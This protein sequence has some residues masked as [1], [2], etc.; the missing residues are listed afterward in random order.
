MLNKQYY[1]GYEG[2]GGIK[3]WYEEEQYE[4]GM[5]IWIGFWET[6]LEG[7]YNPDYQRNGIAECYF[8]H[9]GFYDDKWEMKSMDVVLE[10]LNIFNEKGLDTVD[11]KIIDESK[12]IIK[13]LCCFI[14]MAIKNKKTVYIE[15]NQ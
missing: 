5:V 13:K 4:N 10:E 14:D 9:D 8:N 15:Y 7:C 6:I 1:E 3:I 11:K 12:E 2:E